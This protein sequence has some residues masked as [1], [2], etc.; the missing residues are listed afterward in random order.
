LSESVF[1]QAVGFL[2]CLAAGAM[3]TVLSYPSVKQRPDVFRKTFEP[4]VARFRPKWLLCSQTL[5]SLV[6]GVPVER[7]ATRRL[8]A[9]A[10]HLTFG[11]ATNG[12]FV[13]FSSGTTGLRKGV[14]I[15]DPMLAHQMTA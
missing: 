1:D 12:L 5:A 2:A 8:S 6:A 3:P 11:G 7:L 14:A 15:T 10:S 4:L 13:Q 9:S